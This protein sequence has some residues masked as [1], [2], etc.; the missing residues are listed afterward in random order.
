MT[1]WSN[2]ARLVRGPVARVPAP[3]L[4]TIDGGDD[5]EEIYRKIREAM[6]AHDFK[7]APLD[8]TQEWRDATDLKNARAEIARLQSCLDRLHGSTFSDRCYHALKSRAYDAEAEVK[9]LHA[10]QAA[11]VCA[12]EEFARWPNLPDVP[13]GTV[14]VDAATGE[15]KDFALRPEQ[16]TGITRAAEKHIRTLLPTGVRIVEGWHER[17]ALAAELDRMKRA[18]DRDGEL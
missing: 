11:Y 4:V 17:D 15:S 8:G 1:W 7:V 3:V 16:I 9:R 10:E 13:F 2:L 14:L 6:K 5:R 18:E 12:W